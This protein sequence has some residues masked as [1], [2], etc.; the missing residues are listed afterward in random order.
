MSPM[1]WGLFQ[2]ANLGSAILWIPVLIAPGSIGMLGALRRRQSAT[3][4]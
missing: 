1:R 4:R 2:A 3:G